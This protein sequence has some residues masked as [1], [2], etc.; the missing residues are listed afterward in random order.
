[1]VDISPKF[2]TPKEIL[3]HLFAFPPNRETLGGTAYLIQDKDGNILIDCPSTDTSYLDFLTT[4]GGVKW[5]II[6]H[7][8][9]ISQGIKTLQTRFNPQVVIQEQEA[10]L[11]PEIS[12]TSYEQSL[13]LNPSVTLIWVPGH[14]PGSCC[15]YWESHQGVLFTG[16]HLLPN[17]QGVLSPIR[18]GKTFHWP[19]QLRSV[20][21]LQE[22]FTSETLAYVCPGANTGFLRGKGYISDAYRC[23][24]SLDLNYL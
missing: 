20:A 9:G 10:Y 24:M 18:G 12:V 17:P 1:M 3:P 23:L 5:L 2:K 8:E 22:R 6:T 4:Q 7:R 15:V 21:Q 16:R 14:S 11:L 13:A 19:R